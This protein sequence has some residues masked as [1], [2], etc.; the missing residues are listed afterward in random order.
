[1]AISVSLGYQEYQIIS[2]ELLPLTRVDRLARNDLSAR[3][4]HES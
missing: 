1:M 4:G 3:I 2:L